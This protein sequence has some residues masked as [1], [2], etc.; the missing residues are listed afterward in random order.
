LTDYVFDF[1]KSALVILTF[2]FVYVNAKYSFELNI[3]R[4]FRQLIG[5]TFVSS[6]AELMF[7]TSLNEFNYKAT[8]FFLILFL[9]IELYM[10][11]V[12]DVYVYTFGLKDNSPKNAKILK[13]RYKAD[14]VTYLIMCA[15]LFMN[16]PGKFLY[17]VNVDNT[18][19]L[20]RFYFFIP[21]MMLYFFGDVIIALILFHEDYS[22]KHTVLFVLFHLSIIVNSILPEVIFQRYILTH[23]LASI[24]ELLIMTT[25]ETADEQEIRRVIHSTRVLEMQLRGEI[26]DKTREIKMHNDRIR[27][28]DNSLLEVLGAI[29]DAKDR[30]TSG[31]SKRVAAYSRL[32]AKRLGYDE[33]VQNKVYSMGILHDIGKVGVPNSIINKK[34]KLTD[35]E[36]AK[37]KTHTTVGA[38]ILS[39]V[40]MEPELA[41]GAR[42]HHERMD[43]K[44]YPD[45]LTEEYIPK[46]VRIIGTADAYDAM[47]SNRSYREALPQEVVR[48]EIENGIGKQFD[49]EAGRVMLEL[50]DEDKD[51]SMKE[52]QKVNSDE[53][54]YL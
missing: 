10:L 27:G 54:E 16:I 14:F 34:G 7:Y 24:I 13:F 1:E 49:E 12:F 39:K 37:V 9:V 4:R 36:F 11:F 33:D 2:L 20:G 40:T 25:F 21:L 8:A 52:S 45:G 35:N 23:F 43:G 5:T 38:G 46:L 22:I 44:G 26:Y 31:H 17:R 50:I 41:E 47:T 28:L 29:I 15:V 48:R 18:V 42:W 53:N 19:T 30:Y 51:Y 32:I 3:N 6:L